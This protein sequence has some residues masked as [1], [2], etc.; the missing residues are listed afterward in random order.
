MD[1]E[2]RARLNDIADAISILA[3]KVKLLNEKMDREFPRK[4]EDEDFERA[5]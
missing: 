1:E 4:D 3:F 5:Y 2:Q